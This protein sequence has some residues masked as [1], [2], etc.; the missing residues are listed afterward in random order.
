MKKNFLIIF[1]LI[2]SITL[3]AK[4][5]EVSKKFEKE[6]AKHFESDVVKT[7]EIKELSKF[8][9]LFFKVFD[10]DKELGLVVLTSAKGRYDMFDYM[11]V[12]NQKLEVELIKILVY[13]S[14]YG[15][16]ITAKR[17]LKQFYSKQTENLKYG[18]DIQAISGATFSATSLTKNVNRINKFLRENINSTE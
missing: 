13:R 6:L 5:P 9:D 11:I 18:S 17:W 16:E 8:S 7:I 1:F 2:A 4:P 12:Y 14:D 15:S 10:G 3:M